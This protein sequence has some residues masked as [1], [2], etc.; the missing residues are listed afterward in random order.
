MCTHADTVANCAS[1]A[2]PE[3]AVRPRR[4][5]RDDEGH[6]RAAAF[7]RA[8]ELRDR[9]LLLQI[10]DGMLRLSYGLSR[11]TTVNTKR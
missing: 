3:G 11:F 7:N 4:P 10:N 8:V 5:R 1:A 6:T 9:C 2:M